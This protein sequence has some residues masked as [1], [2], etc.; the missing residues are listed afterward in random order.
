MVRLSTFIRVF[1]AALLTTLILLLGGCRT[2]DRSVDQKA[3]AVKIV[4]SMGL[5]EN[6]HLYIDLERLYKEAFARLGYSFEMISAPTKRSLIDADSGVV[7][8]DAARVYNLND[9]R[10]YPDLLRL[11]EPVARVKIVVY[12]N[13]SSLNIR[14][15]DD[16]KGLNIAYI[17][18]IKFIEGKLAPYNENRNVATFFKPA[19]I[20]KQMLEGSIDVYIDREGVI[21]SALEAEGLTSIVKIATLEELDL[22]PYLHKSSSHLVDSLA[23]I[24]RDMKADGTYDELIGR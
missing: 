12:S 22:Y 23:D 17:E 5:S 1:M 7:D 8:G 4:F 15:W 24:L 18:G 10:D 9:N 19:V 2:R 14:S 20:F 13:N 6:D 21:E 3:K 11:E 16:L